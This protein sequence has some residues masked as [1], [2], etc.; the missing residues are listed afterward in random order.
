[1]ICSDDP[2]V[3]CSLLGAANVA[4][5]SLVAEE[6]TCSVPDVEVVSSLLEDTAGPEE[7]TTEAL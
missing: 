7:F 5:D 6:E 2:I 3:V 1:M 4:V